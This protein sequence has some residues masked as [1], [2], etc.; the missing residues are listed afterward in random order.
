[1][2]WRGDDKDHIFFDEHSPTT[3][4]RTNPTR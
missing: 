3:T 2:P 1:M 4:T